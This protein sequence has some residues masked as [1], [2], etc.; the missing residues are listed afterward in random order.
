[1][2]VYALHKAYGA[3]PTHQPEVD[4]KI[5]YLAFAARTI[6]PLTMDY[7]SYINHV[8]RIALALKAFAISLHSCIDLTDNPLPSCGPCPT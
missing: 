1:M 6:H 5:S 7:G 4:C 3:Y 2:W 8:V